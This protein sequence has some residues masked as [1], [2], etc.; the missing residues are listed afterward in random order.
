MEEEKNNKKFVYTREKNG[1]KELALKV[2]EENPLEAEFEEAERQG[3]YPAH[4]N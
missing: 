1:S 3:S 4:W 2:Y